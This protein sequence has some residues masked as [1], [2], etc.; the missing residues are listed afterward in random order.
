M[1]CLNTISGLNV[2]AEAKALRIK[3]AHNPEC[4][5][6]GSVEDGIVIC[7]EFGIRTR[8]IGAGA[9]SSEFLA[10]WTGANSQSA[11]NAIVQSYFC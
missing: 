7:T 11:R 9:G 2:K 4:T 6:S 5:Y 10:R 1:N 8:F 3:N